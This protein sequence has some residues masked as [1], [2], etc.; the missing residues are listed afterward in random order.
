MEGVVGAVEGDSSGW[1]QEV[2]IHVG[3]NLVKSAGGLDNCSSHGFL[4]WRELLESLEE[5][6]PRNCGLS[7]CMA[8]TTSLKFSSF[9]L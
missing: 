4:Q 3:Q 5:Q 6:F 7:H 2:Q 1:H 9:F 8:D